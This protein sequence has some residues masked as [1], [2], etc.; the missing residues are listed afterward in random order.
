MLFFGNYNDVIIYLKYQLSTQFGMKD[1]GP[2][3]CIFGM[4]TMRERGRGGHKSSVGLE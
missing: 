1:L 4:E 2:K 3:K